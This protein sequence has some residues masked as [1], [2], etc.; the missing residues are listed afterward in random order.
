[1]LVSGVVLSASTLTAIM[2]GCQPDGTAADWTPQALSQS[3]A[4]LLTDLCET[5]LPRTDTPGAIDLG[6]PKYIDDMVANYMKQKNKTRF[7]EGLDQVNKDA[8]TQH[9]K[10]YLELS[11]TEKM[12]MLTAYDKE[13]YAYNQDIK[14]KPKDPDAVPPFFGKLKSLTF[15]GYFL[16]ETGASQVLK[17]EWIPGGYD[18]C[19][20]LSEVGGAWVDA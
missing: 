12:D 11:E 3:Q 9:G 4:D 15:S 14:G 10:A 5:I 20:P 6:V 13:A 8:Q 19:L 17:Y 16:T 2:S 1:M 18:G 7:I